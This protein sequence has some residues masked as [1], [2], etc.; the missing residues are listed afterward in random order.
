MSAPNTP[1]ALPASLWHSLQGWVQAVG[2]V[3]DVAVVAEQQARGVRGFAAHLAH[4]A[5][6][7]APA[8]QQHH[9]GDLAVDTVGVVALGA[10]GTGEQVP[11]GPTPEAATHH[12]HVLHE[13]KLV[14]VGEEDD[15][16]LHG[17]IIILILLLAG[18]ALHV[19]EC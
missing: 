19:S 15:C 12:A 17:V 18:R 9:L 5:L 2:V 10:L 7:A 13:H 1:F 11:L 8:L 4:D 16:V 14:S 6:H 3:A